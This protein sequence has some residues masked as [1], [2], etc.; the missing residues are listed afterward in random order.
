LKRIFSE[1]DLDNYDI[2]MRTTE[3]F[4]YEAVQNLMARRLPKIKRRKATKRV[5]KGFYEAW[6][7]EL[8][9]V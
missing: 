3:P 1:F 7:V 4:H 8:R 2:F 5:Y 6:F 9:R